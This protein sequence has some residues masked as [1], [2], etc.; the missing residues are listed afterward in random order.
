MFP[1]RIVIARARLAVRPP[2]GPGWAHEIKHDGHRVVVVSRAGKLRLRSRNGHDVT[3][4]FITPL[5]PL[6]EIGA[7]FILDGEI[8][9]PDERGVTDLRRLRWAMSERR[10]ERLAYFAFDLLWL[11]GRDLRALPFAERKV[12]LRK[13]IAGASPRVLVVDELQG[14]PGPL[15]EAVLAL[16]GEGIVSKRVDAPYRGGVSRDWRK[17]KRPAS[18][19]VG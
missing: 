18:H 4:R 3:G 10:P 9:V 1:D 7:D 19:L 14:D 11:D 8:A 2:S 5:A 17:I 13:L 6:S 15:L 16:G 12:A